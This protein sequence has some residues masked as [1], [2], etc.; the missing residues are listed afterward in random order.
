MLVHGKKAGGFL[1]LSIQA[2][3]WYYREM[4]LLG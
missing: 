3:L 4:L 2:E 1:A